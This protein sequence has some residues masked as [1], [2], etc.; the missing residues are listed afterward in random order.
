MKKPTFEGPQPFP[1]EEIPLVITPKTAAT[2][3]AAPTPETFSLLDVL[4]VPLATAENVTKVFHA[5]GRTW[6]ITVKTDALYDPEEFFSLGVLMSA[7]RKVQPVRI[8]VDA[9][10]PFTIKDPQYIGALHLLTKVCVSPSFGFDEWAEFGR[11]IG[12]RVISTIVD[13]ALKSNGFTDEILLAEEMEVG[14]STGAEL[15]RIESSAPAL[16]S[17]D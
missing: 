5:C 8:S 16:T 17:K 1:L 9:T 11:R 7:N 2:T 14:E 12:G 4:S 3:A 13:F 6:Q 15:L 10:H